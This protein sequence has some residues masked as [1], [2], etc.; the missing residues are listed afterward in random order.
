MTNSFGRSSM[1]ELSSVDPR[2]K[3]LANIVLTIKDHSV[4]QGHRNKEEQNEAFR[5]GASELK[6]PDG[7][8]NARPS[9]AIDV[10]TYPRPADEQALREE[11]LYLLGLYRGV[12][13]CHHIKVRTGADWDHDGEINDN[14]FDDFF[15]VEVLDG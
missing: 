2:L 1:R 9:M 10:Q 3:K 7:K 6:W 4:I 8:H 15:H 14:E 5:L 13:H 12:A 11:Q